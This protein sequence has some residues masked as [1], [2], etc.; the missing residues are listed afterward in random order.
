MS[1]SNRKIVSI[2]QEPEQKNLSKAQ[3]QFNAWIKKIDAQ[4]KLLLEWKETI[5]VYQKKRQEQY[6]ALWDTYNTHRVELAHLLDRAYDDRLF[7]KRDKHK[8]AHIILE[9]TE[10]L[11]AERGED[12]KELYNK[13]SESD[14]DTD[15][16]DAQSFETELLKSM[17]KSMFDVDLPDDFDMSSPEKFQEAM[18]EKMQEQMAGQA[19]R[20]QQAKERQSKRK[21][22]A[23]QL[24]NE[25]KQKEQ[26]QNVSKSIQEVYRK[27][28]KTLHPDRERDEAERARKTELM[29]RVNN[30][31]TKKD[32][33]QLLE[34]QLEIEQIDQNHLNNIAEDRLKY[35]NKILKEQLDELSQ[36]ISDI[37]YAFKLSL[38]LPPYAGLAPKTL[39]KL[40]D[41]D[42]QGMRRSISAIKGDLKEFQDFA[43]L[44]RFLKDYKIS[45]QSRSDDFDEFDFF[46]N[47]FDSF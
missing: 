3:K 32:L 30:A 8:I 31:Y 16:Q 39:I 35:F 29:Q 5:P 44:K 28:V 6:E 1:P 27:L 2:K 22:T 9:I 37:E 19:E 18:R 11:I 47:D 23:R 14:F 46:L 4:K 33:L 7:K 13:Y 43:N 25:A 15:K 21:K 20:E 26:E 34:L 40:L 45:K 42:I 36:E 41:D 17:A 10:N 24:E 38:S 12:I